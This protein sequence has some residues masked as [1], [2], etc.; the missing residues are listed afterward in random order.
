MLRRRPTGLAIA[1]VSLALVLQVIAIAGRPAVARAVSVQS[2]CPVS[3]IALA[4]LHGTDRGCRFRV[5]AR[6]ADKR[7]VHEDCTIVG[8]K[9]DDILRGT[10]GK[11]VIC[12][13]KGDDVI[14]AR[15]GPDLVY[16]GSGK[17][18]VRGG[19]GRD[20]LQG[21]E[22]NDK[23]VGGAD[24]DDL[25]GQLGND[26]LLGGGWVDFLAGGYG[27]DFMSGGPGGDFAFDTFGSDVAEL[28]AGR[29]GF[30]SR[31]GLDVVRAGRGDDFC[32]T[33][34]DGQ[35]GDIIDGGPGQDHFDADAGDIWTGAEVGPQVCNAC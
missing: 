5:M 10:S 2:V 29:D 13:Y 7:V 25:F 35:P 33:L 30:E 16:G 18:R 15:G 11:D 17:D 22:G 20:E 27:N 8:T 1:V 21:E 31:H 4:G 19:P 14:K 26:R 28:G 6:A 23:L 34:K 32:L 9:R 3:S 24:G 12:G